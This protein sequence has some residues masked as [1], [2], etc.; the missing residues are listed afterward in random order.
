MKI[1]KSYFKR[2][3]KEEVQKLLLQENIFKGGVS[4]L[5]GQPAAMAV[6]NRITQY[7]ANPRYAHVADDLA[8]IAAVV[9]YT[10]TIPHLTGEIGKLRIVMPSEINPQGELFIPKL[11]ASSLDQIDT[12]DIIDLYKNKRTVV[13]FR[14]KLPG[15]AR[16]WESKFIKHL[17]ARD[18][19]PKAPP[20]RQLELFPG[21]SS[22]GKAAANVSNSL[23]A[24]LGTQRTMKEADEIFEKI[25]DEEVR[26]T[27]LKKI[28]AYPG[29]MI[30]LK[31]GP[32]QL[33][34]SHMARVLLNIHRGA[35]PELEWWDAEV[36]DKLGLRNP[37]IYTRP[38]A[39]MT[40][41]EGR[42]EAALRGF[43]NVEPLEGWELFN[44]VI[45]AQKSATEAG[46][47]AVA[48]DFLTPEQLADI[49]D[50]AP[51]QKTQYGYTYANI[52]PIEGMPIMAPNESTAWA[53]ADLDYLTRHSEYRPR[54]L[55][56][57]SRVIRALIERG[58]TPALDAFEKM[59]A[60]WGFPETGI[61][62]YGK[63][64][65]VES[66][67]ASVE[68]N[69]QKYGFPRDIEEQ[70][71]TAME[72]DR[73][74]MVVGE[75]VKRLAN[76]E[77][78]KKFGLTL[79]EIRAIEDELI[80]TAKKDYEDALKRVGQNKF[81]REFVGSIKSGKK[82]IPAGT[83]GVVHNL[84]IYKDFKEA[85]P[86]PDPKVQKA[87]DDLGGIE[88]LARTPEYFLPG[89]KYV[90]ETTARI[91]ELQDML[92]QT[93]DRLRPDEITQAKT[94]IEALQGY[95]DKFKASPAPPKGSRPQLVSPDEQALR[96]ISTR[97]QRAEEKQR[98][99]YDEEGNAIDAKTGLKIEDL[100]PEDLKESR[101][102]LIIK[103]EYQKFL[104]EITTNER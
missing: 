76:K 95:V 16:S 8:K 3:F 79:D 40:G 88:Q 47:G 90:T 2:I 75:E 86:H 55:R 62:V 91:E 5:T 39:D 85:A 30:H 102:R 21:Y 23:M 33:T 7:M 104:I 63:D 89:G 94:H 53:A 32:V 25:R 27:D 93:R 31:K 61:R 82:I 34:D 22:E 74:L 37:S 54:G 1:K 57:S 96:D 15:E 103:E 78:V 38:S 97:T 6:L 92:A 80:Q 24:K 35:P 84:Q 4:S 70:G 45:N 99:V 51:I 56:P 44:A 52:S 41:V 64:Q 11:E 50:T 43:P 10:H 87:I 42:P 9:Q 68:G 73:R 12:A 17:P 14:Q 48:E 101:L 13:P 20:S 58:G 36:G 59:G 46:H 71:T 69:I 81:V 19:V 72:L 66:I 100:S 29:A 49:F 67:L 60:R 98:I 26:W 83:K 28:W 65:D 18:P 77:I